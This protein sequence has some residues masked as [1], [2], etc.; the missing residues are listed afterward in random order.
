MIY[1]RITP[2]AI[3]LTCIES[4]LISSFGYLSPAKTRILT[5]FSKQ[6][7]KNERT[8]AIS[9]DVGGCHT[10]CYIP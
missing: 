8:T 9:T 2:E 4:Q 3:Y 1:V 6:N 10:M 5:G 7:L